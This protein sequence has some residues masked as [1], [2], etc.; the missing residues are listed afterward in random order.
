MA[1]TNRT[2]AMALLP[3]RRISM[4]SI[5]CAN[6]SGQAEARTIGAASRRRGNFMLWQI[7]RTVDFSYRQDFASNYPIGKAG[8]PSPISSTCCTG[9]P[10]YPGDGGNPPRNSQSQLAFWFCGSG[11]SC[12]YCPG[13]WF[14]MHGMTCTIRLRHPGWRCDPFASSP[15]WWCSYGRPCNPCWHR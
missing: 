3:S 12:P 9:S 14:L 6:A 5:N 11:I 10:G 2:L 8:K 15:S 13:N 1:V 7:L 4:S